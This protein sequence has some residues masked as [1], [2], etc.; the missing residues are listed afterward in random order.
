MARRTYVKM[1]KRDHL[2]IREYNKLMFYAE[3]AINND[4]IG[5]DDREYLLSKLDN[6]KNPRWKRQ[7]VRNTSTDNK[8]HARGKKA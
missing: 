3:F 4:D 1:K 8:A 2:T 5:E 7:Y 6:F